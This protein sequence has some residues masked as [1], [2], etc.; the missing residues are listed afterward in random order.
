MSAGIITFF[1]IAA[2][3]S[4]FAL[5]AKDFLSRKP[6]PTT[7][8]TSLAGDPSSTANTTAPFVVRNRS[9]LCVLLLVIGIFLLVIGAIVLLMSFVA[10]TTESIVPMFIVGLVFMLLGIMI[11]GITY[12]VQRTRLEVSSDT[13]TVYGSFG[14]PSTVHVDEI[15]TLE[16]V[17]NDALGGIIARSGTKKLFAASRLM[18]G[19]PELIDFL[20]RR[21]PDLTVPE[22]SRPLQGTQLPDES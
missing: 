16:S 17:G 22:E 21:R 10:T 3:S 19:Y 4:A 5:F 18:T 11:L 6:F 13:V 7:T 12:S 2:V 8:Q 1:V 14:A 20:V 9:W 15:S